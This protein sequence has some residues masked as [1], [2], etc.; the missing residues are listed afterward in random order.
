MTL[1][2][3]HTHTRAS[4]RVVNNTHVT[5]PVAAV[6]P[7]K[8]GYIV[9]NDS[10]L[11]RLLFAPDTISTSLTYVGIRSRDDVPYRIVLL[12]TTYLPAVHILLLLLYIVTMSIIIITNVG[13]GDWDRSRSSESSRSSGSDGENA[14]TSIVLRF[15]LCL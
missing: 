8:K 1:A 9:L 14:R 12:Y 10:Q 11:E 5:R 4:P 3:T 7:C 6:L 2:H 13:G 15:R